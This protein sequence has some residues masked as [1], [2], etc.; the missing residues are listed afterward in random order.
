MAASPKINLFNPNELMNDADAEALE[1]Q[2]QQQAAPGEQTQQTETPPSET[3]PATE[4]AK[5]AAEHEPAVPYE[6]FKQLSDNYKSAER[7]LNELREYRARLDERQKMLKE[8]NDAAE[9][10]AARQ[11]QAAERPDPALD[12]VGAELYDLKQAREQD[13]ATIQQLQSGLNNFAGNYQ[14][15]QEQGRFNSWV[16]NEARSYHA[17]DPAYFDAAKYAADK[18]INFWKAIGPNAPEG[19]AQKLVEAESLMI[20]RWAQ[21]YGGKFAPAIATLAREWGYAAPAQSQPQ[22]QPRVAQPQVAQQ[23]QRLQQVAAGQRVQGLNA[24]PASGQE[25][26]TAY[27]NYGPADLAAMSEQ[28]FMAAM[29]DPAKKRDLKFAMQ[30]ADG[31]GEQE[32]NW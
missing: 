19:A 3:A 9:Q 24:V 5:P 8:A 16:D 1:T 31:L 14:T 11:R 15:E 26:V 20:A 21:Q 12:P 27:R 29:A 17:T 25:G 30:K 18:R 7:E 4:P 23:Q 6:R 10:A 32:I 2:P 22:T 28:E 13:R